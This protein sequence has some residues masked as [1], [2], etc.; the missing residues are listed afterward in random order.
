MK[1]YFKMILLTSS[2]PT[3]SPNLDSIIL[4]CAGIFLFM[5]SYE[6]QFTATVTV[7]VAAAAAVRGR[8]IRLHS[9]TLQF[10]VC[11]FCPWFHSSVA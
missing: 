8:L 11:L 5:H 4:P 7:N 3:P 10:L 9:A 2:L 6:N 1:Y